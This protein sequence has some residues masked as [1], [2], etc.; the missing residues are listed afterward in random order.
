MRAVFE[1]CASR[2]A[3]I[4]VLRQRLLAEPQV[5]KASPTAQRRSYNFGLAVPTLPSVLDAVVIVKP[6]TVLLWHR[7]GFRYYWRW[8]SWQPGGRSRIDREVVS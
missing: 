7:R 1:V 2:E 8:K 5:A 3:E 4:L 6:D